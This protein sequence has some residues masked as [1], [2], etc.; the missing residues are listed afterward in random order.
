MSTGPNDPQ[1]E[2]ADVDADVDPDTQ[3][4]PALDDGSTTEWSSEGG[5]V[6]EGPATDAD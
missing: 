6:T 5:A 3:S 1:T 2:K 4:D